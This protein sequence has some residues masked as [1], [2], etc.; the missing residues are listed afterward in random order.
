MPAADHGIRRLC[1]EPVLFDTMIVRYLCMAGASPDLAEAFGGRIIWPAAVEAELQLQARR[2]APLRDL[3]GSRPARVLRV[4]RGS[5]E[6][7]EILDLR[8][9]MG[10]GKGPEKH[11]GEAQCLFFGGT[12]GHPVVTHDDKAREKARESCDGRGRP[13]PPWAH[14]IE[15]F[16]LIDVVHAM[17]RAHACKPRKAWRYYEKAVLDE[18]M[19][20]WPHCVI[21]GGQQQFMRLANELY[22][23]P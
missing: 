12:R 9:D 21:P 13:V 20:M 14:C 19:I 23:M 16:T 11:M 7:D 15:L 1:I 10:P 18:G 2:I 17:V 4:K 22:A 5:E 6:E 3:I 8:A